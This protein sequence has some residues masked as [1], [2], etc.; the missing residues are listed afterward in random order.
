MPRGSTGVLLLEEVIVT[1][2]LSS[3]EAEASEKIDRCSAANFVG[4]A[5]RLS[6]RM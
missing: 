6:G 5:K 2:I 3:V 4:E 1:G